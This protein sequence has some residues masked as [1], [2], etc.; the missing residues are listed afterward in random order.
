MSGLGASALLPA[1]ASAAPG[2]RLLPGAITDVPGIRVGHFTDS[3]RPTGCTVVLT[4]AGA[5][6]GVDVRG[7]APGTRETD[8]LDPSNLVEKVHAVLLSGGSAFGLEAAT[9]VVRWLEAHGIG[10]PAGPA[11]VPIVPAAIL[12]DLGVG[13]PSIR[14]DAAAGYAACTAAT[15]E[16]PAEGSVGAGAGATVGKLFGMARA[17]KGG[18]G[19]AS[20]RVGKIT[21]GAIVAVN[22][23]GDVRDPA[24]SA[25]LAG[26]RNPDGSRGSGATDAI[27]RGELPPALQPGMATTIGVVATDAVLTKPQARKLAQMAHD[28]L[29]RAIDP[30]HTMWDGDTIFALGTGQSGLT[31]NMMALGPM[32]ARAT[33]SAIVRAILAAKG[34]TGPN[35]P[36][37]PAAADLR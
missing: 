37:V 19:T 35:L 34:I 12:F 10:Y 18:I 30:V 29:A 14:P 3:R 17:M 16:P 26:A 6:G 27:L 22:A 7:A 25:I 11:L 2:A 20:V 5:V 23:V 28:G 31:G 36:S 24:T 13:D 21:V 9:G 33:E 15:A 32:V 4:E 1:S 8:L